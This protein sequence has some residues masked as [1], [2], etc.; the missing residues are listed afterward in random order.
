VVVVIEENYDGSQVIGGGQA[1]FLKQ[2]AGAGEYFPN[3]HGVSHPSDPNYLALFSGSTLGRSGSDSCISTR[4]Q[5][6]VGEARSAGVSVKGYIESLSS[7][8]GYACRHNPFSEFAD[9]RSS[10]TDF[11]NFPS[12]YSRL[13]Q[14]SFVVPNVYDDMH[15]DGIGSGDR[16]ARAHLSGYAQWARTHGSLLIVLSDED[17]ADPNYRA[18]ER[19][20]ASEKSNYALALIVGAGI[21]SGSIDSGDFNHYAMLRTLEDIFGLGH[22]GASAGAP[23]MI[24]V[25]G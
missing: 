24:N 4:A 2:L 21:K 12:D 7:G 16:W 20:G 6:I 14:L 17:D 18:N 11:V 23:D 3:Y 25:A 19:S 1:P 10:E 22:L 8:R 15:N 9:A 13:P 5:S